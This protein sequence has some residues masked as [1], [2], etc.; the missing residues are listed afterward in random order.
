DSYIVGGINALDGAHPY[1]VSLRQNNDHFCGGSIISKRYILTAG[2]CLI[3]FIDSR[4]LKN[5]TVHAGTNRLSES[6]YIY[7]PEEAIVHPDYDPNLM[8]ND[9]GL[10]RLKTDIQYNKLVQPISIAKTNSVLV[11]DAC[12]LTGWGTLRYLGELPDKLQKVNLKVYS[13]SKCKDLFLSVRSSQICAFSRFGQGACHGDSGSPLVANGIQIGLSSYVKPCARG[14]PDVYTR[15]FS[16]ANW[17]AQYIMLIAMNAVTDFI[18]ACLA[19]TTYGL[20]HPQIVGGNDALNGAYPYQVSLR[21]NLTLDSLSHFCGG[22]IISE[23]Y[24]ITTAQCIN[25]FENP[26]NVYAIVGSN[27]LNATDAV[28]YQVKNL[29]VHAG[30]NNLLRVHDIGLIQVS[31]NII[32]NKNVQ[33]IVLSTTDRNFDDYPLLITGWGDLWSNGFAFNRLQEIIVRGYSHKLCSRWTYV[34]QTHICTFTMEN[35]GFCHGDAGSPL[36]ADGVLVGLMSY[37][38]GPCGE[39]TPDVSTRISSYRSSKFIFLIRYYKDKKKLFQSTGVDT[40]IVG[41]KNA[42]TG[43]YPYQVSLKQ[44]RNHFCGGAIIH[45][46]YVITAAHCLSGRSPENI[47]V[48]V[49]SIHLKNPETR[50]LAY[51]LIIHPDY[52]ETLLINDIGLINLSSKISFTNNTK[53]IN[54]TSYDGDFENLQLNFT[55]WG[56]LNAHGSI[57]EQLQQVVAYGFSQKECPE[58][59]S[60]FTNQYI[61]TLNAV[62]QG[63]CNGDSGSALTYKGDLVG[64]LSFGGQPCASGYPDVFTKVYYYKNWINKTINAGSNQQLNIILGTF[65]TYLCISFM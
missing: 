22:A 37:S 23:H 47:S 17:L 46:K 25:R 29:I 31:S 53:L 20:P 39:G 10:L 52:N 27:C 36:V 1:I 42:S 51:K 9:I 43:Q 16:F 34:K 6:G 4:S 8:F 24:I 48:D 55:G 3:K 40:Q 62:N 33:P 63:A 19:F 7:I 50:Y 32:F 38:Y 54:L 65:M 44:N 28:V 21:N 60:N 35:K 14:F 11:G 45:E 30:F 41:G 59:N 26:Y 2:H 13:Q 5:V 49:G 56:R 57:S 58:K 15:V 18:I 12:F 64:I 61:C